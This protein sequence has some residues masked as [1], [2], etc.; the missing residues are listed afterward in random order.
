MALKVSV[1]GIRG[2]WGESLTLDV[3]REYTEAFGKMLL[4]RSQGGRVKVLLGR[5]GRKTGPVISQYVASVLNALGIDVLDA[6]LVPTPSVLFGVREWNLD[7]GIVLTASHNPIEWNALKFVV[8]GGTFTTEKDLEHLLALKG[9]DFPY[10]SWR[11]IGT[12]MK[13]EA[14]VEAHIERVLSVVNTEI[15][16][17]K[18]YTVVLDPVNSAGG[19]ITTKLLEALGCTVIGVN[20]EL[21]GEFSRVAEPTPANLSHLSEHILS[22]HA[23]VAFAQDPDADRLV[24]ADETGRL[25]SEEWTVAL[26]VRHVL[27]KTP[28]PVVVNLSTSLLSEMFARKVGQSCFYTKVGEANVVEGIKT[29]GAVIGGEGNGGVIYPRANLGRDSLVGIA[30]VLE[31]MAMSD[32]SLSSLVEDFPRL[33]SLKEKFPQ[34]IDMDTLQKRLFQVFPEASFTTLDGIRMDL[35]RGE[36]R[37]W[38]HVRTSNTEP[39]VRLIGESTSDEWL[40]EVGDTL[41]QMLKG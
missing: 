25:L 41:R 12:T 21:T 18:R 23:D 32:K 13:T 5:D 15:I 6:G 1:S 40:R 27:S 2:I 24:M 10:A 26:A 9:G 35:A 33:F 4:E 8:R 3:L 14:L 31:A 29:Y 28:G 7:G 20:T 37:L 11:D 34:T 22:H 17:K 39:I 38:V 30:L 16:Q 36:E 19:P